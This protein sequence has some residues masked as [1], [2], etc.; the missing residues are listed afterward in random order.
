M[1]LNF[2]GDIMKTTLISVIVFCFVSYSSFAETKCY[3]TVKPPISK[4][5]AYNK[6]AG[7]ILMTAIAAAI[8]HTTLQRDRIVYPR[9]TEYYEPT[10]VVHYDRPRRRPYHYNRRRRNNRRRRW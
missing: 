6:I 4:S 7:G 1:G 10:R 5:E 9:P 3:D 2:K 8:V